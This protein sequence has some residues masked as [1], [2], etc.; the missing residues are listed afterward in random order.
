MISV[1][2][3]EAFLS[4][5]D[6]LGCSGKLSGSLLKPPPGTWQFPGKW[7][8]SA[9]G[10][11]W[12]RSHPGVGVGQT[13]RR[14]QSLPDLGEQDRRDNGAQGLYPSPCPRGRWTVESQGQ[15]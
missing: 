13:E 14:F 4:N 7:H 2:K 11:P 1:A 5:K 6:W 15:R 3:E 12:V 8:P 9:P 10:C